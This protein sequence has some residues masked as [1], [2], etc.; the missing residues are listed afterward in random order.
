VER[1]VNRARQIRRLAQVA[2]VSGLCL[3]ATGATALVL[4][5]GTSRVDTTTLVT[6]PY[7]P[8]PGHGPLL[9]DPPARPDDRGRGV[10]GF[11]DRRVQLPRGSAPAPAGVAALPAPTATDPAGPSPAEPSGGEPTP[12][13]VVPSPAG[14]GPVP[15]HPPVISR[16][17]VVVRPPV[18]DRPGTIAGMPKPDVP[19]VPI[20][21]PP[22]PPPPR[23][24]MPTLR[25]PVRPTIRRPF[26]ERPAWMRDGQPA[27]AFG[28]NGRTSRLK[29]GR[30][31]WKS[32]ERPAQRLRERATR[33]DA[34]GK[35]LRKHP[36]KLRHRVGR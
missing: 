26:T 2:G 13:P 28:N 8:D 3:I 10:L 5:V 12:S 11:P 20:V 29:P 9:V 35:R 22:K 6:A 36:A 7:T 18:V 27:R 25:K 19:A 16:P 14:P 24:V 21:R 33:I 31:T 30:P 4:T 17:P 15:S 23:V 1:L 32:G 34:A